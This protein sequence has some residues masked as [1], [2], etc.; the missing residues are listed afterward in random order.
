MSTMVAKVHSLDAA[1]NTHFVQPITVET[2]DTISKKGRV[3][4]EISKQWKE[5]QLQIIEELKAYGKQK[6]QYKI[7]MP[8]RIWNVLS[9][10]LC[11]GTVC[12]PC[13]AWDC[14][15]CCCSLL[16]AGSNPF[17][18]GCT[19]KAIDDACTTTFEDKRT[20][21]L[22]GVKSNTL[23]V[24]VFAEVCN[25]YVAAYDQEMER[26]TTQGAMR[27]NIIRERAFH[28]VAV[29]SPLFK[30]SLIRDDGNIDRI[31]QIAATIKEDVAKNAFVR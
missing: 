2:I 18:W 12:L 16:C 14:V 22:L 24:D 8:R 30:Y 13:V 4:Y 28:T 25:A 11:C 6:P 7:G 1:G 10:G 17:K 5:A 3:N 19:F 15:C 26:K 9:T 21:F 23:D 20:M 29:Y 31:R 27:A